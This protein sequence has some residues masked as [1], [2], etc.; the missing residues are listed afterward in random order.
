M[1]CLITITSL[2]IASTLRSTCGAI[3]YVLQEEG[4]KGP[5]ILRI[6]LKKDNVY[7]GT[8]CP[9]MDHGSWCLWS[10]CLII[11]VALPA[12]HSQK[13]VTNNTCK[14]QPCEKGCM[15]YKLL[16]TWGLLPCMIWVF[17][18]FSCNLFIDTAVLV[19]LL[20]WKIIKQRA[21]SQIKNK[22][23]TRTD[24]ILF[25]LKQKLN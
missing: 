14:L 15:R 20:C 13:R 3:L 9:G 24:N 22:F 12:S 6:L 19:L 16:Y 4:A 5:L 10:W 11:T 7:F 23:G 25:S 21:Y 2:W 18:L 17:Y 1:T 8:V